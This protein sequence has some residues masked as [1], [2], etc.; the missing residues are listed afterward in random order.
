MKNLMTLKAPIH[1]Q[2]S[3]T[4][5]DHIIVSVSGGKDSGVLLAWAIQNFPKEKL[6]AV[7]AMI[8]IDWNETLQITK[9][10]CA[11]FGVELVC[12]QAIDKDGNEKGFIDQLTSKRVNRK[13]GEVGQYQWPSMSSRWCTSVLKTGPIDKYCRAL[14]GNVLVLI[15]ERAEES[16]QRSKLEP[17]RVD[18]KNS[19]AGRNIIKHSP[20]LALTEKDVW[21]LTA[22]SKI[23]VHPCYSWGVSR[24][25]C[26]ICIFSS[27]EEIAIAAKHAPT[28]VAKMIAAE[29]KIDHTF[30]FKKATKKNPEQK[31]TIE[32]ILAEQGVKVGA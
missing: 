3:N 21:A 10:Q 20:I 22:E 25:S 17:V 18:D 29:K 14:S 8:D 11:H 15:G 5:W 2:I 23:P 4:N 28:I 7:H 12:V 6:V 26:A 31:Q 1:S 32:Q 9:D 27:K 30:R 16:A 19:K 24:A 13:T